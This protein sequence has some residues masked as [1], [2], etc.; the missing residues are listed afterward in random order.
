MEYAKCLVQLSEVMNRLGKEYLEKIPQDL[1][2]S[3]AEQM[4]KSYTWNYDET[5]ELNEQK[6]DRKTI[7]MLSCLNMKYLLNEEQKKLMDEYHRANEKRALKIKQ[8]NYNSFPNQEKVKEETENVS[9][10]KVVTPKWY[11][12]IVLFIKKVMKR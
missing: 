10:T 1:R 4:D 2:N 12:K 5:K 6:L 8:E 3:V 9:M 11:E 7:A